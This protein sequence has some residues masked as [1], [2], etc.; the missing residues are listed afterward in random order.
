MCCLFGALAMENCSL[1]TI[2][3]YSGEALPQTI[4]GCFAPTACLSW[5]PLFRFPRAPLY[6]TRFSNQLVDP[7]S[8][9][10]NPAFPTSSPGRVRSM[11]SAF[12]TTVAR[13]KWP[14]ARS[15]E[16]KPR[17][18]LKEPARVLQPGCIGLP[19]RPLVVR[20]LKRAEGPG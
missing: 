13:K 8:N 15:L 14:M 19:A 5:R 2:L 10:G 12:C 18:S 20:H 16:S 3:G 7:F 11:S 4:A 17:R 6:P 9:H 1:Y